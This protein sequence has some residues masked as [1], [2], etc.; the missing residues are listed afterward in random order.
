MGEYILAFFMLRYL[1]SSLR[2]SAMLPRWDKIFQ[3]GMIAS[4]VLLVVGVASGEINQF[5]SWFAYI[6]LLYL[7]YLIYTIEEFSE[8]KSVFAAVLPYVL[9]SFLT[10][11][12][13]LVNTNFYQSWESYFKVA[14]GFSIIYMI[15]ML[16]ITNKQNKALAREREKTLQEEKQN[17]IM[18]QLKANLE[19]QVVERT[20]ELTK[21]KEE[22]Q[23][24][25][26]ELKMAQTQLIHSEKMAS[27][28][29]LT[30]GIAHE[31]QNPL[32]FVNNF[33]EV[34]KEL[35]EELIEAQ[36][37]GDQ[38]ALE[39]ITRDLL[40]NEDKIMHH[41]KRAEAIV[42]SML[43]HSR[44]SSG[45]KEPTDIN[46]LADEYL[47]LAYHG[48]RAKDKS[49]NANFKADLADDLPKI[50][51][52]AQDI[53][54]VLLNLVN[55]AFQAVRDV[56]DPEVLVRTQMKDGAVIITV[57]DNGPGI[58]EDIKAKIF[59][60]FFTTKASGEGTGLGL[61]LSYDIVTKG[62]GGEI[63]VNSEAGKGTEFFIKLPY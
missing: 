21:Q 63:D 27:L 24:A 25:L 11:I 39:S 47:R 22:L 16:I 32:N 2:D 51:V 33:S 7:A 10:K 40:E 54:R 60:P 5:T 20:A 56:E 23:Q 58:P 19:V 30:A 52:V 50:N 44:N 3:G 45:E 34:N 8:R 62:H 55:N 57:I 59:Q 18:A 61:S 9:V 42:K 17:K 26:D 43:Q 36:T 29:E 13:Q 37:N 28:G 35:L 48:F 53:G 14:G 46:A 41:G 49:F 6:I 1:R 12:V 31:I 15:V 4:V 38:D